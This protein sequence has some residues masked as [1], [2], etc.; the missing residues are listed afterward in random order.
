MSVGFGDLL[1]TRGRGG[2]SRVKCA[3]CGGSAR[4]A[5]S[6]Q[7][8]GVLGFV[9]GLLVGAALGAHFG[10]QSEQSTFYVLGAALAGG[11]FLSF[12]SGYAFLTL[13]PDT[14]PPE[15]AKKR[16]RSGKKRKNK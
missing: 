6:S 14:A 10:S 11:F 9:V 16:D 3:G 8:V 13:E 2:P 7:V 12:I 15:P 5:S 4:V 1:P